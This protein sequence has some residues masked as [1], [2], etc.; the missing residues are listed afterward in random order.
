[1]FFSAHMS[2]PRGLLKEKCSLTYAIYIFDR[3]SVQVKC[4]KQYRGRLN[5]SVSI[6]IFTT[7]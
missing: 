6:L 3:T 2:S 4:I 1:M 5:C 7:L